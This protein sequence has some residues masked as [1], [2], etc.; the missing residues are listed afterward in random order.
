MA[1]FVT[2]DDPVIKYFVQQL[3]QKVMRGTTVGAGAD[4]EEVGR[5][6][7]A[8]YSFWVANGMVY[9]GTEGLPEKTGTATTMIQHVRLPREVLS[10]QAG[11][12]VELAIL[13]A[14]IAEAA[15]LHPL[16]MTTSGHAWPVI[17]VEGGYIPIEATAIGMPGMGEKH[18]PASFEEAIKD[19]QKNL[20][21]WL[22]GGNND[23]GVTIGAFDIIEL[24]QRGIVPPE[25]PDDPALRQKI[26]DTFAR[27]VRNEPPPRAAD[28]EGDEG[29]EPT[30]EPRRETRPRAVAPGEEGTWS[31]HTD[32]RGFFE[33]AIPAGWQV[34]EAPYPQAP[35]YTLQAGD[36]AT[37]ASIEVY[38]FEGMGNS[39]AALSRIEVFVASGGGMLT[40]EPVGTVNIGSRPFERF[41]GVTSFPARGAAYEWDA[42][43][44]VGGG[45]TIVLSAGAPQG[46]LSASRALL[47]RVVGT[48]RVGA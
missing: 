20:G 5:F 29:R 14:S 46:R 37:G 43:I 15:G 16:I 26:D 22:R 9:A 47:T 42:Y 32:P 21:A 35:W 30:R 10:G 1:A 27:L 48:F 44:R 13:F 12:C 4:T 45:R 36:P 40:C 19:G 6:M 18:K 34:A 7:N 39:A 8:V 11:L 3:E 25:L 33:V 2:P 23:I 41:S 24:H 31:K 17:Q 28:V 38:V